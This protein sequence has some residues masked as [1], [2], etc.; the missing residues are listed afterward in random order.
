V[1]L[2]ASP[3]WHE[4]VITAGLKIPLSRWESLRSICDEALF[5][6]SHLPKTLSVLLDGSRQERAAL[7]C[8]AEITGRSTN[9]MVFSEL[10]PHSLSHATR[11]SRLTTSINELLTSD[12]DLYERLPSKTQVAI[13]DYVGP[14][15]FEAVAQR[16]N[17]E[18][19][20]DFSIK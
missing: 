12:R 20:V 2:S 16:E 6:R 18:A 4:V 1:L 5:V 19:K 13:S 9:L 11:S 17:G 15:I 7:F 8:L 14:R 10:L 3:V